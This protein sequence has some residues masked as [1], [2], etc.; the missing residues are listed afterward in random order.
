MA[1]SEEDRAE[2]EQIVVDQLRLSHSPQRQPRPPG[3]LVYEGNGSYW[4]ESEQ[5]GYAKGPSGTLIRI[6]APAALPAGR[7][8]R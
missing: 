4:S 2:V 3:D 6:G 5:A 7:R 8:G 1:L